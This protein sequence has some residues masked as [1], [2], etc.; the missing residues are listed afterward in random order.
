MLVIH[1]DFEPP[2]SVLA[3]SPMTIGLLGAMVPVMLL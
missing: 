2:L 3:V 1:S